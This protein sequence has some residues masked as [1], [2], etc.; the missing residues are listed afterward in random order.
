MEEFGE[1]SD[2]TKN[3]IFLFVRFSVPELLVHIK[4]RTKT[5]KTVTFRPLNKIV[6]ISFSFKDIV[7]GV[8][9]VVQWDLR[10]LSLKWPSGLRIL[11]C[12]SCPVGRN[13]GW[14]PIPGPGA[15]YAIGWPKKKKKKKVQAFWWW[16]ECSTHL[17]IQGLG[18]SVIISTQFPRWAR[19]STYNWQVVGKRS[20]GWW[21]RFF[22]ASSQ[23]GIDHFCPH[24][25]GQSHGHT[26]HQGRMGNRLSEP[27]AMK[28]V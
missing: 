8:P 23:S 24:F 9:A 22:W 5:N 4:Q 27:K 6:V 11:H 20:A 26:S 7:C 25:I 18:G 3:W 28:Y 17:V 13:C 19:A 1:R 12:H 16:F 15:L 2:I 10:H 21:L 14:D